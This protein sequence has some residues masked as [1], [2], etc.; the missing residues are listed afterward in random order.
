MRMRRITNAELMKEKKA[1][2]SVGMSGIM[3]GVV[4]EGVTSLVLWVLSECRVRRARG[5]R[6]FVEPSSGNK[7]RS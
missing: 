7:S 6:A 2:A 3:L 5:R 4:L 1:S